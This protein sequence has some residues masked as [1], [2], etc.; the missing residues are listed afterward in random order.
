MVPYGGLEQLAIRQ[1][2]IS[3]TGRKLLN[4][5][6]LIGDEAQAKLLSKAANE[7]NG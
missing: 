4:C 7:E 6:E 2:L 5:S 3:S 1:T